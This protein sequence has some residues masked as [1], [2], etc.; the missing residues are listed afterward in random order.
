[1]D[2][3]SLPGTS[4]RADDVGNLIRRCVPEDIDFLMEVAEHRYGPK[5]FDRVQG[6]AWTLARL[7]EPTMAFFRGRHSFGVCH[8]TKHYMAPT[9]WQAFLTVMASIP[10][11]TMSM[12]PYRICE[13]MVEWAQSK[14]ATKFWF[15]DITGHDLAPMV[16][17]LGG[18]RAGHTYVVDLDPE[19]GPFG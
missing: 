15:S 14:N 3:D 12:E 9:K 13:A 8:I 16:R 18:R 17:H 1:M 10:Q 11:K 2:T 7:S 4:E 5:D 6:R 19:A